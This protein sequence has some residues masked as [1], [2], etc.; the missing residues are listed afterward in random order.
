MAIHVGWD[1]FPSHPPRSTRVTWGVYD[2][3]HLGHQAVLHGLSAWA[4][5][6]GAE[7]VVL[8]FDPHPQAFLRQ[9]EI[10][11]VMPVAERVRLIARCG[12][13]T[14]I[15][16]PF[17]GPFSELSP[18]R[19]YVDLLKGRLGAGGILIGYDARFGH[20]GSGAGPELR[21]LAAPDGIPVRSSD[22][23]LL[24]GRPVK[25]SRL[26]EAIARGDLAGARAMMRRPVCLVGPVVTG[27]RRGRQ[28]G[29]P[30]ANLD[31]RGLVLPPS[32]VYAIRGWERPRGGGAVGDEEAGP[33]PGAMY[34][35]SR[36]TFGPSGRAVVEVH[37][38][39]FPPD[40]DLYGATLRIE[41][42]RQ[43]RGDMAFA[44]AGALKAR[45]AEDCAQALETLRDGSPTGPAADCA[46]S[47]EPPAA[48]P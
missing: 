35:G 34:I 29:F 45:I 3:I 6:S 7:S 30:T 38:I 20:R 15:V 39:G 23:C 27:D 13:D 44:H 37:F 18:E 19:F 12:I 46:A 9:V 25:S 4:R 41:L 21:A 5:E 26:R 11:L 14:V 42:V 31:C 24:D 16:I 43:L 32:G 10:P 48:R 28:L 1:S 22:P 36:P 8:T 40:R 33:F 17:D 2:G 47:T